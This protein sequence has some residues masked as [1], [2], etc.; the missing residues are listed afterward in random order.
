MLMYTLI[1]SGFKLI[2]NWNKYQSTPE[3][4]GKNHYLNYLIGPSFKGSNRI[5]VLLF[6]NET[7]RTGHTIRDYSIIIDD[8][9][10]TRTHNHLVRKR[11]LNQ[12]AKLAKSLSCVVSTYLFDAFDCM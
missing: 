2:I 9:N 6:E 12:L 4:I 8:C 10:G 1:E 11:R 3:I 5:F 7:K